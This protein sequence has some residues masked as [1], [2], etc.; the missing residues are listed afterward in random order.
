MTGGGAVYKD[1]KGE[2]NYSLVIP[3][4]FAQ[5]SGNIRD[6]YKKIND[7]VIKG[8]S[9][10]G[11]EGQHSGINDITV[12]GRRISGNA[13]T[14]KKGVILQ[15]GTVL[16]D[17]DPDK[18]VKYLKI[19]EEKSEDKVTKNLRERVRTLKGL[20]PDLEMEDIKSALVEWI[21]R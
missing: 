14:R 7:C 15:H 5:V 3:E 21:L 9:S 10:L 2:L 18:M 16:L 6:L 19:A 1:L 11:I 8:L 12:E 13:Q 17:F 20:K 4:T